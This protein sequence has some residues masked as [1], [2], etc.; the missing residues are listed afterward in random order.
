MRWNMQLFS[1]WNWL[2]L[3]KIMISSSIHLPKH[4][5]TAFFSKSE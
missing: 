2:N 1:F 5:M 3:L 4:H